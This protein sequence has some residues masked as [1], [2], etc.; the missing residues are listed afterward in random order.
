MS[1]RKGDNLGDTKPC[2]ASPTPLLMWK[3]VTLGA[4]GLRGE[5]VFKKGEV[6]GCVLLLSATRFN[7]PF[8]QTALAS[9]SY[10]TLC[11]SSDRECGQ[12]SVFRQINCMQFVWE[13]YSHNFMG[14]YP[15]IK[16]TFWIDL[17]RPD[18]PNWLTQWTNIIFIPKH[19]LL[20]CSTIYSLRF[21]KM[22]YHFELIELCVAK[23]SNKIPR[24]Y[25]K[26]VKSVFKNNQ[27][28]VICKT[29]PTFCTPCKIDIMRFAPLYIRGAMS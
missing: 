6:W 23:H 29:E 14:F 11:F 13:E 8:A 15:S 26:H 21:V 24:L 28:C 20:H 19:E 16:I 5:V 3:T 12:I 22:G 18:T 10:L 4:K 9:R 27:Y 7:P 25:V 1:H 17:L 2:A